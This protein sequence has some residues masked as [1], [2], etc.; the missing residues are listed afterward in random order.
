MS[1][2]TFSCNN[3]LTGIENVSVYFAPDC[4]LGGSDTL[5]GGDGIVDYLIGGAYDDVIYGEDGMDLAFGDHASIWLYEDETHKLQYATTTEASCTP[6]ADTI[7]LGSGDDIAFGGAL[8]DTITGGDGQD[9]ILGD[10]GLYNAD[11]EFLPYQNF[12]SIIDDSDQAGSDF[13]DG[14]D[15]DDVLMGQ[16]GEDVIDGGNG[17]DDIYGGKCWAS[18]KPHRAGSAR[19]WLTRETSVTLTLSGHN[20]RHGSDAGDLLSGGDGDDVIL[21]DNGEIVRELV[22]SSSNYPWKTGMVWKSYPSPFDSEVIRDIR[23]YDDIDGVFG[24]DEIYG[25]AGNDILHGQR[26]DDYISGGDGEDELYG[27]LGNDTLEGGR[28]EDILIGDIGYCVRRYEASDTPLL[29]ANTEY[30]VWHKDIILEDLGSITASHRISTKVDTSELLAED[31]MTASLLFVANAVTSD[32]TGD[33]YY[34]ENGEW[35]TELILFDMEPSYDDKLDGGDGNDWI[36]GQRGDD[37]LTGGLGNDLLVGDAGTNMIVQD[38]NLPRVYQVYRTLAAPEDSGYVVDSTDFGAVFTFD[39]ELYPN[40][41]RQVDSLSSIIDKVTNVDDIKEGSNLLHDVLGISALSTESSYCMQPMLRVTPGFLQGKTQWL[42]GND[43]IETGGGGDSIVIGDDIRGATPVDLTQLSDITDRR[44]ALDNLIVDLS[45][46]L[47]TLEVDTDHFADIGSG[48][49]YDIT[50][51][52]DTITTYSSNGNS[53]GQALVTGDS[54][55]ILGRSV[56]GDVLG[57]ENIDGM[58]NRLFDIELTLVDL[59]LALYEVHTNLLHR[60]QAANLSDVKDTQTSKHALHLSNDIIDSYNNGDVIIGDSAALFLQADRPSASGFEFEEFSNSV[61]NTLRKALSATTTSREAEIEAH[62]TSLSITEPLSNTEQSALP[63]AD[64]PFELTVGSDTLTLH[65]ATN[66]AVGDFALMGITVSESTVS[67][68]A[69]LQQYTDS[70]DILRDPPSV[71]SFMPLTYFDNTVE[72]Y[73]ERSQAAK[74]VEKFIHGDTF[75]GISTDNSM[76]G[77][78]Y[79]GVGYV[80]YDAADSSDFVFDDKYSA[81]DTFNNANFAINYDG[82]TFDIVDGSAVDGQKGQDEGDNSNGKVDTSE[83]TKNLF[84]NHAMIVQMKEDIYTTSIDP[85][86]IDDGLKEGY[87]CTNP[88]TSSYI[89]SFEYGPLAAYSENLIT[90]NTI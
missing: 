28:G 87:E 18:C 35:I 64:V 65:D 36:F 6:G 30:S 16:E 8:G 15:G 48:L 57:S 71:A 43:E 13:L 19:T 78:F 89:P 47:S 27:E 74:D 61:V 76:L 41:Y 73:Y 66:L 54:L 3:V 39:Y 69:D 45:V 44:E 9:I 62:I 1:V 82:D 26:G 37:K 21:G 70:I 77:E 17:S 88:I 7:S 50:V 32:G 51:G 63:F 12:E 33:K 22:S 60:V 80:K 83:I 49:D 29:Q 86:S 4:A 5:R 42:H 90:S 31:V 38:M 79:T 10:F 55:T 2:A 75:V 56:L 24:D 84:Y 67:K 81:Y 72:Y 52:S 23:R 68:A 53:D 59:S 25:E 40:Q 34:D 11:V 46:R 14:G 58:L 85:T 20:K